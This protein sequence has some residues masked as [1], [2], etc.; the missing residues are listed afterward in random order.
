MYAALK[1]E[2]RA[3][4]T[5]PALRLTGVCAL[6]PALMPPIP[7]LPIDLSHTGDDAKRQKLGF[8][9][10]AFRNFDV[11]KSNLMNREEFR[12]A[13]SC[14]YEFLSKEEVDKCFEVCRLLDLLPCS[15]LKKSSCSLFAGRSIIRLNMR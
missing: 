3:Q 10:L 7:L 14:N 11:S 5:P 2:E 9:A 15:C 13:L 8:L 6:S 1:I 4:G 12:R